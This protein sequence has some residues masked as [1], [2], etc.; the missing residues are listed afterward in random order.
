MRKVHLNL[1][2]QFPNL[3]PVRDY[4]Y[5]LINLVLVFSGLV[6]G[7]IAIAVVV[8]KKKRK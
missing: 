5:G 3:R 1:E 2:N 8:I 4:D 6:G 7:G